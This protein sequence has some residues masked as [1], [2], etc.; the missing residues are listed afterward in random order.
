MAVKYFTDAIKCNPKEF[1]LFGNRSLCYERIQ[2]YENALLDADVAISMEPSW[3]KGLFRKGK[4]LSGLKRYYEASLIYQQVL[5]LESTSNEAKQ[6]LKR[7]QT[8]HLMELGFS[9]AQSSVAL[10]TYATLEEAVEALFVANKHAALYAADAGAT[11]DPLVLQD[12]D[13]GDEEWHVQ[14]LSRSRTDLI[15]ESG[16]S[17]SHSLSPTPHYR[18]STKPELFSVWVG[19][20]SPAMTYVRLHELFSRTGTVYSIKMLLDQQCAF[21][22]YTS[23]EDRERAIKCLHGML[24]DGTPLTVR[25]PFKAHTGLGATDPFARASPHKKE[26]FFWRTTGC[27]RQDCTF[28]HVPENKNI[29]RERFTSRLGYMGNQ[30]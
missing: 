29:D 11:A 8:L 22:N 10:K 30:K 1:R 17:R 13:E 3:I 26:C 4:A 16:K 7:A 25:H 2:Q 18:N 5:K 28:R 14:H 20:L 19:V 9:W 23:H 6:E 27:T 24:V 15:R 12:E 21:V